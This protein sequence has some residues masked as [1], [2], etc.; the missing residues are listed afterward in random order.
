MNK[1]SPFSSFALIKNSFD[2]GEDY[3]GAYVPLLLYLFS[4][5]EYKTVTVEK[6]CE[7]FAVEYGFGIPRHPM[8]TILNR[9]KPK[10][11]RK[12]GLSISVS[13]AEVIKS[14]KKIDIQS[15]IQKYDWL[16]NNFVKFCA[17]FSPSVEVSHDEADKLFTDFLREHALDIIFAASDDDQASLLSGEIE[18]DEPDKKYLLNRYIN[19]LMKQG[20]VYAEY[21]IQCAV[22]HNYAST[23]LYREF[24]NIRGRGTCANYYLDVGILFD[25]TGINGGFRRK[26]ASDFLALL[27]KKGA[28]LHIFQH[29]FEEFLRIIEGC[30]LWVDNK[31][32]DR[33]KASRALHFFKE[34]GFGSAEISL[35]IENISATLEKNHIEVVDS[36]NPNL[37]QEYQ[38]DREAFKR[39]LLEYYKSDGWQFEQEEKQNTIERDINSIEAIY[40]LRDGIVPRSL[41]DAK[42]VLVTTNSGLAYVSVLF[43]KIEM[44][45]GF[46]T[47][48]T[49]L[50]DIFIG[51]FIW[52]Q[53]P[54]KIVE[55]FNRSKLI[56]YTNAV[57][58]PKPNLLRKF[59]HEVEL[60][61]RN[62]V[63]PIDEKSATMM[64]DSELSRS[65]LADKTL[66]DPDRITAQ[67]PYEILEELK[68]LLV[69]DEE[70][71]TSEALKALE[72]ER[73]DN[74][75]TKKYLNA[76]TA[77][78]KNL[79]D[80]I[81]VWGR[82]VVFWLLFAL[83]LVL[84]AI[85]EFQD[86]QSTFAKVLN[87]IIAIA[88]MVSGITVVALGVKAEEWIRNKL[89]EI[90]LPT[91][92]DIN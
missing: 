30:L 5:N 32:Y 40:K 68:H 18:L 13:V 61:K 24:Q 11:L 70:N 38:I 44:K 21:I 46:F 71:K 72:G 64:L 89:T 36:L 86:T 55:D 45:R 88:S 66:G 33:D 26:S 52:A 62:E 77:N 51:T 1:N 14:A 35:F 69:R 85:N 80:F 74:D 2:E 43:E 17:D 54:A 39:Q 63:N 37:K 29:N 27:R 75:K 28:K 67:T 4:K 49:A 56:T 23:I 50:T 91:K 10:Y 41:N 8:E 60:A 47:I 65:L 16:I 48:P 79:I 78:I 53:E 58:A 84:L 3:I 12:N 81:A 42:H 87:Y 9:M 92:T 73:A 25:L 59:T 31:R 7:D 83:T 57:I 76:Q 34:Q 15:E 19:M 20:G 90:L 22:G 6:V 82:K